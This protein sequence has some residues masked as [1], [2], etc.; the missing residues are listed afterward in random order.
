MKL[1]VK[2]EVCE[3]LVSF[4]LGVFELFFT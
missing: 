3:I 1:F 2:E 4:S